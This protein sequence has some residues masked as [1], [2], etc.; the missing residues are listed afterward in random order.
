MQLW[1]DHARSILLNDAAARE[2]LRAGYPRRLTG[3]IFRILG[4]LVGL[5]LSYLFDG[6]R[7]LV[8]AGADLG[9]EFGDYVGDD[10][11]A[12][13]RPRRKARKRSSD[14]KVTSRKRAIAIGLSEARREGGA[15]AP[16]KRSKRK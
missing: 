9:E 8:T 6:P 14:K 11:P 5:D 2:R 10:K 16:K 13:Q 7:D 4:A 3:T 12:K 1:S 15:V